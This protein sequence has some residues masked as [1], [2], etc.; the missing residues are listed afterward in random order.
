MKIHGYEIE[1]KEIQDTI[2]KHKKLIDDNLK[3]LGLT[4]D[5]LKDVPEKQKNLTIH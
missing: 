4:I 3:E 5:D 2:K 1:L